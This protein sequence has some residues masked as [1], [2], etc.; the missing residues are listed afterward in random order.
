MRRGR[1]GLADGLNL[2]RRNSLRR[3]RRIRLV[4]LEMIRMAIVHHR[5]L[6]RC[7]LN[8]WRRI[9]IL[10]CVKHGVEKMRPDHDVAGPDFRHGLLGG[11]LALDLLALRLLGF[12]PIS[13]QYSVAK[14]FL[15]R[16]F[17]GG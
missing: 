1:R 16:P 8:R 13:H 7:V 10:D 2:L 3:M 6:R 12:R 4:L 11:I 9:R 17:Q 15:L 5:T 14:P